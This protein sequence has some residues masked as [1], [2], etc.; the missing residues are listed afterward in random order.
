M[1]KYFAALCCALGAVSLFGSQPGPPTNLRIQSDLIAETIPATRRI[2]WSNNTG[3]DPVGGIPNYT[4]VTCNGLDPTGATNNTTQI[5]SCVNAA[6]SGT[7][8]FIPAGTYLV[9]GTVNMRSNIA[10]RGAKAAVRPW[11]DVSP[12]PAS[13]VIDVAGTGMFLFS[14]GSKSSQFSPTAPTGTAITAGYTKDSTSLTL[15]SATNYNINDFV[16]IY[17]NKDASLIDDKGLTYLGEDCGSCSDPHVF[18]MMA[19]VTGKSGNTIT[20]DPPLDATS[21][22]PTGQ[23]VRKIGFGMVN[24]GLENLRFRGSGP[25]RPITFRFSR[26]CWVKGIE[27]YNLGDSDGSGSPHIWTEF[28]YGNE[29]RDSYFHKGT[30]ND[31]GRNYGIE[32]YYWNARHKIENNI[33]R[34]TRHSI[35]FEGGGSGNA[36]LYNYTD[37]NWES[38]QGAGTSLDTSF[39]SEDSVPNHGAHPF[40]NLWEGNHA[41]SMAADYT[42]G[43][44]SHG[45][46]FRNQITCK[47]ETL[48]MSNPWAWYCVEVEYYNRYYTLVG[49][50]IGN[51]GMTGG[52]VLCNSGSCGALPIMMHFGYDGYGGA[53]RDNLSYSTAYLHGNYDYV[54]DGVPTSG[55]QSGVTHTLPLSLYYGAAPSWWGSCTW[56]PYGPDVTGLTH[57]T[58]ADA[59]YHGT[60]CN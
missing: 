27:T 26:N 55:W 3:L 24:A 23:S 44:S 29:Y 17:Q 4:N 10:I 48:S 19:K 8:V 16:V 60:T 12:D 9:S 56:P 36:I 30:S 51:S 22:S 53:Y 43:S 2:N 57:V 13:T 25:Y 58:P 34:L 33:V 42:Q 7:A 35:I 6:A 59:R 46:L 54:T 18:A 14:G 41:S 38:V 21:A 5:Q 47:H 15:S 50:V 28:S 40:M 39:L 20:I 45:M 37:D 32:F 1:S 52:T 49:N 11:L 31:S